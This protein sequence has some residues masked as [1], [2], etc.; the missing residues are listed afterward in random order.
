MAA[1]RSHPKVRPAK[2]IGYS[3]KRIV[4]HPSI[5]AARNGFFKKERK[6]IDGEAP[7]DFLRIYEYGEARKLSSDKWPAYI[8]KVGQKWYPNESITEHLLTRIGQSFGFTMAESR[9]MWVK[10]QL[11]FL[12]RYF[13]KSNE[14]LVHGA[15]IFGNYL[16]DPKFVE[17]VEAENESRNIFT[18]KC[19]EDAIHSI[20][21]DEAREIMGQFVRLLGFD[22]LV[23]N[24]DRHFYNWGVIEDVRGKNA[25]RLAPIYDSARALFWNNPDQFLYEQAHSKDLKRREHFMRKYVE[26][27]QPKTGWDGMGAPNHFELIENIA[28]RDEHYLKILESV[29]PSS[30]EKSLIF[31]FEGEF[32]GLLSSERQSFMVECLVERR[33]RLRSVLDILS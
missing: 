2:I 9:L 5:E 30:I 23:G 27:C 14:S 11:R 22:A 31:L 29:I 4:S 16:S 3:G 6:A 10:G 33:S 28:K 13:L 15:E 21:P 7:K 8:A 24:N 25:P 1:R 32:K 20:F 19:V 26:N 12:S 18:F 17:E